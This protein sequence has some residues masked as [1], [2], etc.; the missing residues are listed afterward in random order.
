MKYIPAIV[1]MACCSLGRAAEPFDRVTW[2]MDGPVLFPGKTLQPDPAYRG[3]WLVA[4]DLD[5][6]GQAEIVTARNDQQIVTT[7]LANKL[8]G[9][10]LWRW[11]QANAG[12]YHLGYDV[13]VQL[14]D[15]DGD[16]QLEV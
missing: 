9:S 8:D 16:G 1:L 2:E 11:G 5:N 6:D 15:L 7:V 13:P 4:G 3:Q 12:R 10:V 14:Y